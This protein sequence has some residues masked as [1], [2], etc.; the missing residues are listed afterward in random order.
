[1]LL[2]SLNHC[3]YSSFSFLDLRTHHLFTPRPISSALMRK[4]GRKIKATNGGTCKF[5]VVR[6]SHFCSFEYCGSL[7]STLSWVRNLLYGQ[8]RWRLLTEQIIKWLVVLCWRFFWHKLLDMVS[9]LT[10]KKV[11]KIV[12]IF[13]MEQKYSLLRSTML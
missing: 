7:Q 12:I 4:T 8:A 6:K 10:K 13:T 1:M 11:L 3:L 2:L 5:C 9:M